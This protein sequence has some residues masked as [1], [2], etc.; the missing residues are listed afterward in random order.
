MAKTHLDAPGGART[1]RY[2]PSDL[3]IV[4]D[5]S[6][7]LCKHGGVRDEIDDDLV[8]TMPGIGV[9]RHVRVWRDP[10]TRKP[11]IVDGRRRTMHAI[12]AEKRFNCEIW[13]DVSVSKAATV[14]DLV[15]EIIVGHNHQQTDSPVERGRQVIDARKNGI[16]E[17]E[18][19]ALFGNVTA[20]TI[21]NWVLCARLPIAVQRRLEAGEITMVQ[22]LGRSGNDRNGAAKKVRPKA[23]IVRKVAK[24]A[25]LP[26]PLLKWIEW[27]EGKAEASEVDRLIPGFMDA[28]NKAQTKKEPVS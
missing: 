7:P 18:I 17:D 26:G 11:L 23:A 10:E 2:R 19:I 22:A 6:H 27:T 14:A 5:P 1:F 13:I 3:V 28:L 8:A 9:I 12:E 15:R 25:T 24:L 21:N 4:R 20:A 16:E